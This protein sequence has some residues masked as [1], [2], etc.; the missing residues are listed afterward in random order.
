MYEIV[1]TEQFDNRYLKLIKGNKELENKVKKAIT[2][3]QQNYVYPSLKTHKA[4]T[5]RFGSKC[6]S[7]VTGDIRIIWDFESESSIILLDLGGH[8]GSKSVY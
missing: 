3:L 8:S 2:L 4:N 7:T 1:F 6:S 5:R